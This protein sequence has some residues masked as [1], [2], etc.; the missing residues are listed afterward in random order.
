[1][2]QSRLGEMERR[3]IRNMLTLGIGMIASGPA[4]WM[5]MPFGFIF[6]PAL[7]V[8]GI[9]CVVRAATLSSKSK[10]QP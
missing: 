4:L 10:P 2:T 5:F 7:L 1:M 3:M 8:L 6:G 9:L